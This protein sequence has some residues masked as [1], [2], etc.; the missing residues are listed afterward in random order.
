MKSNGNLFPASGKDRD[1]FQIPI[2]K[3]K[4]QKKLFEKRVR[5]IL[6]EPIKKN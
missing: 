5:D 6:D 4:R 1:K 3:M 2:W